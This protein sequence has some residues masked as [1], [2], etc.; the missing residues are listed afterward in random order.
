[1]HLENNALRREGYKWGYVH[2]ARTPTYTLSPLVRNAETCQTP[3]VAE[4]ERHH[5]VL[6]S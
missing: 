2:T 3:N 5:T 1:L 4:V 6:M